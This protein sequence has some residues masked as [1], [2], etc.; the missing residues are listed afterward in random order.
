VSPDATT[1]TVVPR[2]VDRAVLR[3]RV[4]AA[5]ES[6]AIGASVAAWSVVSGLVV[7]LA[8]ALWR[9]RFA[10][11]RAVVEALE[12]ANPAS[13]N[14]FVTADEIDRGLV[15]A[16]PEVRA[17]VMADAARAADSTRP[18]AAL[19]AR[20]LGALV[21]L[22]VVA[23][24][25]VA[26]GIAPRTRPVDVPFTGSAASAGGNATQ[27]AVL[28]VVVTI[29]PP[30]YTGLASTTL[31]DPPELQA[32]E[33]SRLTFSIRSGGHR[34]T[35]EANNSKRTLDPVHPGVF[36]Y[37][38]AIARSGFVLFTAD[39]GGRR[40][41]PIGMMPDAPP[42][43]WLVAPGRDLVFAGG[44]ATIRFDARATDDY[45]LGSLALR[46]TKV[47]GSGE[48]FEFVEGEVPL[49]IA[50]TSAREWEGSA[51]RSL[52][53][54]GLAEGDMLVY[55]AVATEGRPGA[56][57]SSSD[58]F[59]IEI[60][61]VGAA[62]GDAFTL[63]QEETRYALSQQMLIVKTERLNQRRAS[64]P[65]TKL[66]GDLIEA[67]QGLAI[68]QRMI[69]SEFVF[70]LGGEVED[71]EVEAAQS[72]ELQ[73]GRLAN[74][75][76]RDLRAAT[77]AMSQAEKLLTAGDTVEALKAERAAVAALQRAFARDRY[78]LRA[79]ATRAQL[80]LARRLTGVISPGKMTVGWRRL[81]ADVPAN[82]RAALLQSLL[83][84]LGEVTA[85]ARD[86]KSSGW[87][88]QIAVLAEL[89]IRIDAQSQA[90]RTA[91]ADLQRLEDRWPG[92]SGDDRVSALNSVADVVSGE[93]GRSLAD[94]PASMG[95]TR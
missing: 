3:A 67:S 49:S 61:K 6:A 73:E 23:W 92:M 26:A 95:G 72:T 50:K 93:A 22:A 74:R 44:S 90:L 4:L 52:T 60:S 36:A 34:V 33:N 12:R 37:R 70:M 66:T 18:A 16:R 78:I 56:R 81:L 2:L 43:V 20:R 89:A 15:R 13:Q 10:S 76:Q 75:G 28:H 64:I 53:E 9:S 48:Q 45:G 84:G 47:S 25:T 35:V 68:E 80:D 58:A 11:K 14:L 86:D 40:M 91:A 94:P 46:Y 88:S 42:A 41:M 30:S 24:A 27:P 77:V 79:L 51:A 17:R 21:L 31:T 83:Q 39:D 82:R 65:E 85:V 29:E 59:F 7:A 62:A 57:E 69:R 87:R 32:I 54:L 38:D 19:P 63:P 5:A 1:S 8:F 71:E 55:R